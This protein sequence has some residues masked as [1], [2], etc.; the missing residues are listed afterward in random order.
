MKSGIFAVVNI[1]DLKLYVGEV[2]QLKTRWKALMMLFIRGQFPHSQ[3]QEVWNQKGEQRRFAFYTAND[4][5]KDKDIIGK[6]QFFM[7]ID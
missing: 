5:V 7:D 6:E 3:L 4:V 1:G 2:H